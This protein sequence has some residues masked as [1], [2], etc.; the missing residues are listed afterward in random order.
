LFG[1]VRR[2]LVGSFA[3]AV[4]GLSAATVA[5]PA[6][7]V[8]AAAA[9]ATGAALWTASRARRR[10]RAD[11]ADI[12]T[13]LRLFSR[14]LSAG[15]SV[16]AALTAVSG[17]C[18]TVADLFVSVAAGMGLE[19][20]TSAGSRASPLP[21]VGTL[22]WNRPEDGRARSGPRAKSLH[23][24]TVQVA[25]ISSRLRSGWLMSLR[26][27]VPLA[28]VARSL[29]ADVDDRCA[30]MDRRATETAGGVLSGYLLAALPCAGLLLGAAMGAHPVAVLTSTAIGG[31]LLVAG[32][33]LTCAGLLWSARLSRA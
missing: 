25:E 10:L 17:A 13:A 9:A 6:C 1:R 12:A 21:S 33:L 27:G 15:A 4:A 14:E 30:A 19:A 24:S 2:T 5:G 20:G 11:L 31:L 18:P 29:S 3:A 28:A 23:G 8:A 26:Y 16:P 32:T 7:G 22:S